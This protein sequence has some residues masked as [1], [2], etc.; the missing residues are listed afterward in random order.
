AARGAEVLLTRETDRDFLTPADSALRA[1]LAE[2]TRIANAFRPELF[3]S[4]HHNADAGGAHDRNEIQPYY[5]LGDEGRSLDAAASLHRYLKR[6]LGIERHRIL[7]GHYYVLRNSD[8]PAV[9]TEASFL[10]NP[11][12]EQKLAQPEKRRLEAEAIF[13]GIAH[14]FSRRVPV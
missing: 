12:V 6:N 10:T 3:V 2:R 1:D 8:A 7:P 4:I 11:D 9:L 5:K 14:F 13:L